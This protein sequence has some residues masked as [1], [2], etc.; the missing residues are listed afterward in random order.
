MRGLSLPR[1][2]YSIT[3][4]GASMSHFGL[5][6]LFFTTSAGEW[7]VD[8]ESGDLRAHFRMSMLGRLLCQ[9]KPEESATRKELKELQV[10]VYNRLREL[11]CVNDDE[12]LGDLTPLES[13][14]HQKTF[15]GYVRAQEILNDTLSNK[16]ATLEC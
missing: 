15:E 11:A 7:R 1:I 3:L 12:E 10:D 13:I 5:D 6:K 8:D 14:R 16:N 4:T 2:V 9:Y